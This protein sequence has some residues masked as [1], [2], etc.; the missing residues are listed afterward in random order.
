MCGLESNL[1]V[2][3]LLFWINP[4]KMAFS[5][6][7]L[8]LL[9]INKILLCNEKINSE[10]RIQTRFHVISR[11]QLYILLKSKILCFKWTPKNVCCPKT[12]IIKCVIEFIECSVN[13]GW[14]PKLCKKGEKLLWQNKMK[15]VFSFSHNSPPSTCTP[16]YVEYYRYCNIFCNQNKLFVY[17]TA[18]L[19]R[20]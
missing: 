13:L 8:Y 7:Y 10:L 14:G 18:L 17:W 15:E 3:G 12:I 11:I 20:K 1:T 2:F 5:L 19:D 16:R 6:A 9:T 4:V